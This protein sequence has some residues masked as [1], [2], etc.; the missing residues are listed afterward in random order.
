[1]KSKARSIVA[2]LVL[3]VSACNDAT[4]P[5]TP[6]IPPVGAAAGTYQLASFDGAAIPAVLSFN[7]AGAFGVMSGSLVIGADRSYTRSIQFGN[8]G[9]T[10]S[11]VE[12]GSFRLVGS[13]ITFYPSNKARENG[14]V[15]QLS[16]SEITYGAG[17]P[18][19]VYSFKR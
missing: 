9:D 1:M 7:N 4:A 6:P 19:V 16:G 2:L 13:T 12:T 8:A 11:Q 5:G 18:N 17:I 10:Q 3:A 15:G 14:Y